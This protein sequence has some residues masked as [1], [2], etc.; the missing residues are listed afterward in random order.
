MTAAMRIY[1]ARL[2]EL[3]EISANVVEYDYEGLKPR[4]RIVKS[5]R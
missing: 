5:G 1:V 3:V 2:L 4:L